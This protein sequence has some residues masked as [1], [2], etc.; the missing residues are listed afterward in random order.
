MSKKVSPKVQIQVPGKLFVAGEYAVLEGGPAIIVA[1]NQYLKVTLTSSNGV[2]SLTSDQHPDLTVTWRRQKERL[3]F[4]QRHPYDLV[5][6]ALQT[7]ESYLRDLGYAVEDSVYRVTIASSLTATSGQKY[8]LG[9]SGA[10]TVATIQAVLAY[11]KHPFSALLVYKLAVLAQ[12]QLPLKGSFGDLAASSFG[13]WLAYQGPERSWLLKRMTEQSIKQ[14]VDQEWPG[15]QVE[16]LDLPADLKLLV[17]WTKSEA[18]TD[19]LVNQMQELVSD[20]VKNQQHQEFIRKSRACVAGLIRA[21]KAS[22]KKAILAG[23][24]HNRQLLKAYADDMG[25]MVETP[26][27]EKLIAIAEGAGAASKTS[28]AGGGDC[29]ICF[30]QNPQ[31]ETAIRMAWEC[32]GIQPLSLAP[33]T[34]RDDPK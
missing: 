23:I 34:R 32:E 2:G 12:L 15:L 31:Q 13:G 22:D 18:L 10:V 3:H 4:D 20:E 33:A 21:F 6:A 14:M 1:V 30:V 8:G 7:S 26:L 24:R 25:L 11:F 28:G 9:S 19:V 16:R 5:V 27:L 29:G 17:G